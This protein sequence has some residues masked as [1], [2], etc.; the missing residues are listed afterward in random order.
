MDSTQSLFRSC[1]IPILQNWLINWIFP[2]I[3]FF[4]LLAKE[5]LCSRYPQLSKVGKITPKAFQIFLE[6][7]A[8]KFTGNEDETMD[9]LV[10]F[11]TTSVEQSHNKSLQ[12]SARRKWLQDIQ[13]AAET[14]GT[15]MEPV[16]KAV[17]KALYQVGIL[18]LPE[19]KESQG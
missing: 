18:A 3:F 8:S 6:L 5:E 12:S 16:Y 15:N 2:L 1:L 7:I 10:S 19:L 9:N 13:K 17:I 4:F 14:S 11:L